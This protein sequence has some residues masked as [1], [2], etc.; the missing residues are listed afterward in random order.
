MRN[1]SRSGLVDFKMTALVRE[2]VGKVFQEGIRKAV[3]RCQY[4]GGLHGLEATGR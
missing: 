1:T 2:L 4:A 3:G